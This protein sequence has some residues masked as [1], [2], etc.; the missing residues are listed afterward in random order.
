MSTLVPGP[1]VELVLKILPNVSLVLKSLI[2]VIVVV[3]VV[4]AFWAKFGQKFGY[5]GQKVAFAVCTC[6]NRVENGMLLTSSFD[7]GMQMF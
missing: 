7:T 3:I 6:S 1:N 5:L 4:G 2:V